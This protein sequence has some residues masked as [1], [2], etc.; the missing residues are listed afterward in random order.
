MTEQRICQCGVNGC[1]QPIDAGGNGR[2]KYAPGH[3]QRAHRKRVQAAMAEVGYP[4]SPSLRAAR[5]LGSTKQRNGDAQRA[6]KPRETSRK[7]PSGIQVS[8]VKAY[9]EL[10]D[11]LWQFPGAERLIK[12]ALRTA[13]SDRQR[14]RLDERT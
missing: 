14:Q 5:T 11:R 13:L 7:R 6:G 4:A 10:H 12:E 3:R 1:A 8:Y 2:R 9:E